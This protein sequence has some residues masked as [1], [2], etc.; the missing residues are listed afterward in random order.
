MTPERLAAK[1]ERMRGELNPRGKLAEVVVRAICERLIRGEHP[2]DL[3]TEFGVSEFLVY[4]I[5]S[6]KIWTHVTTPE[7]VAAMMAT[8]QKVWD[9]RVVTQAD[10]ERGRALGLANK[11]REVSEETRAKLAVHSRGESNPKAKL[12]ETKAAQIK[13]LLADEV[14]PRDIA[15]Q[16]GVGESTVRRIKTGESWGYVQP[17]PPL[18][19]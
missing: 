17:A 13:R 16:F 14:H 12:T 5:R 3:G 6:G 11:G 7:M 8:E 18:T 1:A 19:T 10:R 15:A 2:Q 4:Q 9:R